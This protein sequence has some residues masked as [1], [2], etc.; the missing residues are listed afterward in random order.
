ML[1]HTTETVG[2]TYIVLLCLSRKDD[3]FF[4]CFLRFRRTQQI[5]LNGRTYRWNDWKS[6]LTVWMDSKYTLIDK[7][8]YV[9]ENH[10]LIYLRLNL[11]SKVTTFDCIQS[12]LSKKQKNIVRNYWQTQRNCDWLLWAGCMKTSGHS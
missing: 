7:Y 12:A 10:S 6:S 8:H 9:K 2:L 5:N 3:R 4:P 11:G 1:W